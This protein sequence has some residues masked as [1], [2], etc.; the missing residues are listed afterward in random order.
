MGQCVNQKKFCVLEHNAAIYLHTLVGCKG[1]GG[2]RAVVVS[3]CLLQVLVAARDCFIQLHVD[4]IG[5][6]PDYYWS[7]DSPIKIGEQKLWRLLIA[8][9]EEER[10]QYSYDAWPEAVMI[11]ADESQWYISSFRWLDWTHSALEMDVAFEPNRPSLLAT[12]DIQISVPGQRRFLDAWFD[13]SLPV[14]SNTLQPTP[15]HIV[16]TENDDLLISRAGA[17]VV[18]SDC[19]VGYYCDRELN[20]FSCAVAAGFLSGF[21]CDAYDY[22]CCSTA[23]LEAC[24]TDPNECSGAQ[25]PTIQ[26]TPIPSVR[27]LTPSE[28][29]ENLAELIPTSQPISTSCTPDPKWAHPKYGDSCDDYLPGGKSELYACKDQFAKENCCSCTLDQQE[30]KVDECVPDPLWRHPKYG[31]ACVDYKPGGKS[32]QHACKD[33]FARA[34]CCSCPIDS[35]CVIDTLWIHPQYGDMCEDYKPGRKSAKFA[36]KDK[37]AKEK[38]CQC[39]KQ[40][41]STLDCVPDPSWRHPRYGDTCKDYQPGGK[42]EVY[43]CKDTF[44]QKHCCSCPDNNGD[45]CVPDDTWIHPEYQDSCADYAPGGKSEAYACKDKKARKVLLLM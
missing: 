3:T 32:E 1:H 14:E 23:F 21:G 30:Y 28:T 16:D 36:C 41:K 38:C 4:D 20:C 34:N 40:N 37:L 29:G 27:P 39:F 11:D 33:E 45:V 7:S 44:A 19:E 43:A 25:R 10:C 42:S 15:S 26:P 35:S 5:S 12:L 13:F 9:P 6:T 31:D 22:K 18:H 8:Q 2:M 24:P 17:C